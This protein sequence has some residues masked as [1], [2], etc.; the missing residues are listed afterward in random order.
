MKGKC[1]C[2]F[3]FVGLQKMLG[4]RHGSL[5]ASFL[6]F[7]GFECREFGLVDLRITG[8]LTLSNIN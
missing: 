7:G 3:S 2:S 4:S 6:L 1:M 5:L 8:A